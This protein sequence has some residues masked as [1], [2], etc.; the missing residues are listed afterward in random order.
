MEEVIYRDALEDDISSLC[1]FGAQEFTRTFGHLYPP[2]DLAFFLQDSYTPKII[3]NWI[4]DPNYKVILSIYKNEIIGYIVAGICDLEHHD[5]T[6]DDIEIKKLYIHPSQF[7]KGISHQLMKLMLEYIVDK[8][9]KLNLLS[10]FIYLGVWENNFRAQKFYNKYNFN[11][12]G[13]H[14]YIVGNCRDL[15]YIFRAP[16]S[17]FIKK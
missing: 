16:L 7:G 13:E 4:S 15:D 2:E 12:V 14:L 9:T 11:R 1:S 10:S 3:G 8:Q 6:K 5:I 17:T